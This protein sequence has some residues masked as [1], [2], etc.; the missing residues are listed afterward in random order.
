[1]N[2][3][4]KNNVH[5]KFKFLNFDKVYQ[6]YYFI[7]E[8]ITK[9]YEYPADVDPTKLELLQQDNVQLCAIGMQKQATIPVFIDQKFTKLTMLQLKMNTFN[10]FLPVLKL[11][12]K[13][14]YF[15]FFFIE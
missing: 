9:I 12:L 11:Y 10:Y 6:F 14:L 8:F 13:M 15:F 4:P 1:M 5:K 2:F 3:F 7:L